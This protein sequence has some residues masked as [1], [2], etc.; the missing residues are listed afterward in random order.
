[1]TEVTRVPLQPIAKGSL[2]KLWL[3]VVVAVLLAAGIAWAAVP[4][5]VNVEELQ[6]GTGDTAQVGDVV[7]VRY[8]GRLP[9]GTVFDEH[10]PL[11]FPPG[12]LPDGTPFLL[13]EGQVIDGFFEGLQQ[14]RQ[15][16]RY[17][18]EIPADK[19]YGAEP[20]PGAPIPPNSD[21]EFEVEVVEVMSRADAERRLQ[22][23]QQMM[24]M[25][26]QQQ[27]GEGSEALGAPGM[28]GSGPMS[29][30]SAPSAPQ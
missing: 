21:L 26:M 7:F 24:Q 14:V 30:P 12:V 9:D 27:M 23:A 22:A 5:G 13:E 19:G 6:A 25:Q 8:T 17:L 1:M 2:T 11:P 3:G 28:P 15:G 18:I 20:P 29:T 16:G 10:Q 4:Q